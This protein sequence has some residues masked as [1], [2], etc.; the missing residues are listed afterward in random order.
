MNILEG[1]AS[2]QKITDS[3]YTEYGADIKQAVDDIHAKLGM[4]SGNTLVKA[5]HDITEMAQKANSF[6]DLLQCGKQEC[7]FCCHAEIFLGQEEVNY[8][9]ANATYEIDQERL[10]KQ[11]TAT[12][13]SDL[14]FADRACIMLK[15]GKCQVYAH[16][17]TLCRNHGAALGTDPE[18][19]HQQNLNV[20]TVF[21]EQPRAITMEALQVYITMRSMHSI[22]D[23]KNIADYNW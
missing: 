16:R 6:K 21:V 4:L 5:V 10:A 15:N 1:V 9:K 7:S 12:K 13:Y 20:G 17:P 22:D 2:H 8:I 14:S 11:R 3:F 19:C 23:V 18:E